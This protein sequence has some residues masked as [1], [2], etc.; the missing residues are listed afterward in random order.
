MT[1]IQKIYNTFII[2]K[3]TIGKII[4]LIKIV[5]DKKESNVSIKKG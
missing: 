4:L 5:L 2:K 1:K 3:L